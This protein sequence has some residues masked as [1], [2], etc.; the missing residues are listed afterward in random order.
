MQG[1]LNTVACTTDVRESDLLY[2]I[3][4]LQI[5]HFFKISAK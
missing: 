3:M 4:T 5:E 2:T 1:P